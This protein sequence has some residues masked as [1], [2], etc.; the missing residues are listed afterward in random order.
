MFHFCEMT[1][2]IQAQSASLAYFFE[3]LSKVYIYV[4]EFLI[5]KSKTSISS[6][7]LYIVGKLIKMKE[8][9]KEFFSSN[10]NPENATKL[11]D[12][13]LILDKLIK[14]LLLSAAAGYTIHFVFGK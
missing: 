5:T 1:R 6:L 8:F 13:I 2:M 9:L 4:K 10:T 14:Y 12:H 3:I 7:K 11:K